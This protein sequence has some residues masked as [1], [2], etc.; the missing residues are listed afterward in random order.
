MRRLTGGQLPPKWRSCQRVTLSLSMPNPY[1]AL[2]LLEILTA[3]CLHPL[4]ISCCSWV[5]FLKL[6]SQTSQNFYWSR[7]IWINV[8]KR[9]WLVKNSWEH[10]EESSVWITSEVSVACSVSQRK[11]FEK[12]R[13]EDPLRVWLM[14]SSS[15]VLEVSRRN[16]GY[17]EFMVYEYKTPSLI[18]FM[19]FYMCPLYFKSETKLLEVLWRLGWT[20]DT[21]LEQFC[22]IYWIKLGIS[23]PND[24]SKV[25]SWVPFCRVF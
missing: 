11:T 18:A 19:R 10:I 4:E 3:D 15:E 12:W 25:I 9:P 22:W 6:M 20:V 14:Q 24:I 8:E 16:M 21:C 2:V 7:M 5:L 1:C 17:S 13:H 23:L